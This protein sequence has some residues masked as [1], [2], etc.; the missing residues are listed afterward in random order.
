MFRTMMTGVDKWIRRGIL[1]RLVVQ[2]TVTSIEKNARKG[3]TRA[4]LFP[5]FHSG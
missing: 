2:G 3:I 5:S 4:R 1:C